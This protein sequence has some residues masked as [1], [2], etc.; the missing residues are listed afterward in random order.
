MANT[1]EICERLLK[2][3]VY[4]ISLGDT[5]GVAT[6]RQVKEKL[7]TLAGVL[8]VERLAGHFHDTRGTAL[9]NAY[10][11]LEMG[12]T[13]LDSAFGGLG[14]VPTLRVLPVT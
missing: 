9:V 8:P 6:P 2:M 1:V 13:T 11:S 10:V 3:G 14:G 4:E 12:I 7:K 5:I